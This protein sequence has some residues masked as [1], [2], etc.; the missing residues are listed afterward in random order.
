M[1]RGPYAV[2]V[3][4]IIINLGPPSLRRGREPRWRTDI[5]LHLHTQSTPNPPLLEV[6]AQLACFPV[7]QQ[8]KK[9]TSVKP[10]PLLVPS[11]V[12]VFGFEPA[13]APSPASQEDRASCGL[14]RAQSALSSALALSVLG[15]EEEEE[16]EEEE[17]DDEE[18]DAEELD[19]EC[20]CGIGHD[21]PA[22]LHEA[23]CGNPAPGSPPH[24]SSATPQNWRS[25][26]SSPVSIPNTT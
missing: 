1:H 9:M 8:K 5:I 11:P 26:P 14:Q 12:S 18:E 6:E 2:C 24:I 22:A 13:A 15:P 17:E 4:H 3:C 21:V 20:T 16:E 25:S 19:L 23:F 7:V 10:A